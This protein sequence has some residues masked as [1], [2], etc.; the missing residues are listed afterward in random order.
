[1]QVVPAFSRETRARRGFPHDPIWNHRSDC[2][3]L[4]L[5]PCENLALSLPDKRFASVRTLEVFS[6][7]PLGLILGPAKTHGLPRGLHSFAASRLENADFYFIARLRNLLLDLGFG[8]Y[9]SIGRRGKPGRAAL[10][11]QPRA[12]VPT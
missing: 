3:V 5:R 1:M 6:C 11:G 7:A 10:G 12:A 4:R 2:V 8:L 9:V